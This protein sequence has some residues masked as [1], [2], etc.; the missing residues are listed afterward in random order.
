M[1]SLM[2][3]FTNLCLM[4]GDCISIALVSVTA[5]CAA[6]CCEDKHSIVLLG[7]VFAV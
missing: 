6:V 7:A 1:W 3:L 4:G 5:V 2:V